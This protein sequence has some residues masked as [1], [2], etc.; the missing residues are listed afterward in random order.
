[1][2]LL[3]FRPFVSVTN[4]AWKVP[5]LVA[6]EPIET[7]ASAASAVIAAA[8]ATPALMDLFLTCPP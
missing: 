5:W 7:A 4:A 8:S 1:L 2:K 3:S 6:A